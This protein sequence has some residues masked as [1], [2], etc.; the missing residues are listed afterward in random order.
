MG[1]I[2]I[3]ISHHPNQI[4]HHCDVDQQQEQPAGRK[5]RYHFEEFKWKKG[6][7]AN[8]GQELC[9]SQPHKKPD[10]FG[11]QDGGIEKRYRAD[12]S[13]L[14]I[15]KRHYFGNDVP[16][17]FAVTIDT[18]DVKP[19][20]RDGLHILVQQVKRSESDEEQGQAFYYLEESNQEQAL[21]L[22][23]M[24]VGKLHSPGRGGKEFPRWNRF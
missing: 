17:E 14:M 4:G 7:G 16:E 24:H 20:R 3:L 10:T 15:V 8:N 23:A 1:P 18:K 2:R 11:E 12:R 19:I 5:M 13:K 6:T 22:G 9:P 21:I